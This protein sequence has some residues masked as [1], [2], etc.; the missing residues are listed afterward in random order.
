MKVRFVLL[1]LSIFAYMLCKGQSVSVD[2]LK[3][4]LA[5]SKEDTAKVKLLLRIGMIYRSTDPQLALPYTEQARELSSRLGYDDGLA[6]AYKYT[7]LAYYDQGKFIDAMEN[8]NHSL[9]VFEQMNNKIGVS[10][11]QNNIGVIY[12]E[13]GLDDNAQRFFFNSLQN[14]EEAGD[15]LRITTALNN[16]GSVYDHKDATRDKARDYYK[17]ALPGSKQLGD[18][19]LIGATLGNIGETYLK[20]NSNNKDSLLIFGDSALYYF[21]QQK[22]AYESTADISYALYN[23]GRA[24][25]K[26]GKFENALRSLQQAYDSATAMNSTLYLTQALEG[27]GNA[28]DGLGNYSKA[29]ESR[30]KAEKLARDIHS[31]YDLK[32]I[33]NGLAFDYARLSD[34]GNA[35]KYQ[36]LLINLKDSIY[37]R[38]ADLKLASHEFDF[39]IQKKQGLIDL[40]NVSIERQKLARNAFI[41]GFALILIIAVILYRNYRNKLKINRLLDI[42]KAQIETLL[43]NILPTE[44]SREL[45]A[46]GEATPRFYESVS[47]L[48][49]DFKGFT[50]I[51]D[52]LSPQEVVAELSEIFTTFD[53]IMEKHGLEKIKTIGDAYMVAGGIPVETHDHPVKMIKAAMEL[54]HYMRHN[55]LQRKM[56]GNQTWEMRVGIH[57]G[58]IVAGVV[59][60]KKY[61]YDI[62]GSTVNIASRMESNGEPGQ[63]NISAATYNLVKHQFECE[64]RGKVYAKNVGDI[65]MYF[66]KET[67]VKP[68]SITAENASI[69]IPH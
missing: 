8:Y 13:Q 22:K 34:F 26:Q 62:W 32:D 15:V 20:K 40:Q 2:S 17:R 66:V 35:Y 51:A 33:Y 6:L 7:G 14:A 43:S 48:F 31:L 60:R 23:I 12:K 36:S 56:K 30:K 55:N 47:V 37:N 18:N 49:T 5:R 39:E 11:I 21:Q 28:Y 10:N 41:A 25:I 57:T 27:L 61:A 67:W 9:A 46:T 68:T 38:E 63:I 29:L 44:V 3:S 42:Q 45:Q 64:Y 24:Y 59:G 1:Y 65:D 69:T 16:I 52:S 54:V 58:P 50:T 19:D 4:M 53:N